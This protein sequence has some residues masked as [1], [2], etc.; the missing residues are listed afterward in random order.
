MTGTAL[1]VI[2]AVVRDELAAFKTAEL[3]VVTNAYAHAQAGDRNNYECDVRLR[4]SGLELKRVPVGTGRIGA[5]AIPNPDDLVLV[6]FLHGDVH[7]AIVT[8]RLY[9]D[10]DRPPEAADRECVYVCPDAAESGVRRLY[11][12]FPNGNT[13]QLDDDTV[14]LVVSDHGAKRMDGGVCVNEW[15][16]RHGYLAFHEDPAPGRRLPF[17]KME[18][19]WNRTKAWGAGGYYGR[20]FLNVQGREPQG[21]I[22]PAEYEQVRDEL[23]ERFAALTDTQGHPIGARSFKPNEIYRQVL[24]AAPD[25]IVYFG[26]L[27]WR[28]VG[29]LGYDG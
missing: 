15:L 12:E 26:D 23:I 4:D 5:A 27:Y 20:V 10:A 28:A 2:R 22:P 14:V 16:W 29:A 17:E 13:L 8:A 21:I 7:A 11:L 18:V 24:G 25:L 1:S 19:D 6:Q 9:N 3:G